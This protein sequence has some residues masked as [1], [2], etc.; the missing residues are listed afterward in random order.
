MRVMFTGIV[1][2]KYRVSEANYYPERVRY[3]IDYPESALKDLKIGA[4]VSI[5]GTCQTVVQIDHDS[6]KIWFDAIQETL[7]CTTL[8]KIAKNRWVNV[9]RSVRWG[10]EIGGHLLSGHI[11]STAQLEKRLEKS[12]YVIL[13]FQCAKHWMKYFFPK[14]FIALD[15]VSL[16]LVDVDTKGAFSVHLIP[17]TLRMTV[18]GSKSEGDR[19]NIEIDSRTQMV[20]DTVQ[21]MMNSNHSL[22]NDAVDRLESVSF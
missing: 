3:A 1:Q 22:L 16:T 21:R 4:S 11:C 5:D 7:T 9:E 18:L 15:G 6:S 20:V 19:V 10:D 13:K 17:E 8:G 2:G 12:D 14:G